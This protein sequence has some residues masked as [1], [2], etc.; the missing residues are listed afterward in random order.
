MKKRILAILLLLMMLLPMCAMAA[1]DDVYGLAKKKLAT[2]N[3]PSTE[4]MGTATYSVK[5]QYIRIISKAYDVNGVCWLQ[6]E[7]PYNNQYRRLYTGLSR[8]DETT[9]HLD[10]IPTEGEAYAYAQVRKNIK[11]KYGPG[12]NYG[13]YSNIV[14]GEGARVACLATENGYVQVEFYGT[15]S[16]DGKV[17]LQRCWVEDSDLSY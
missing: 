4:Y 16:K 15:N 11:C 10:W 12:E 13:T 5:N 9:V 14:L 17:T 7:I 2:R 1:S 3:G 8:F 6:V